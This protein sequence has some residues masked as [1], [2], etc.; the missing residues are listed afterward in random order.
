MGSTP[1]ASQAAVGGL[2]PSGRP[3][4][5]HHGPAVRWM[6]MVGAALLCISKYSGESQAV[7]QSIDVPPSGGVGS[8]YKQMTPSGQMLGLSPSAAPSHLLGCC[9]HC[10]LACCLEI[11]AASP[12]SAAQHARGSEKRPNCTALRACVK[13]CREPVRVGS[14]ASLLLYCELF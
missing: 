12:L 1:A 7:S 10:C 13:W 11:W 6:E 2:R 8:S 3:T 4:R 14:L 9:G 5:A